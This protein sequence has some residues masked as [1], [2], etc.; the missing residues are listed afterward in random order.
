MTKPSILLWGLGMLLTSIPGLFPENLRMAALLCMA[1]GALFYAMA[2]YKIGASSAGSALVL[3]AASNLAFWLAYGLWHLR[4]NTAGP[5]PKMGVES[6]A[7][8]VS[9]WFTILLLFSLYEGA[10]FLW[11]TIA[12][13]ER[14]VALVG[15]V[16]LVIQTATSTR[17]AY[18]LLQGV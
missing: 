13:R 6:F 18:S 17:L 16:A 4:M 8:V 14:S 3:V 1:L 7:G 15:I 11:G 9:G 5:S 2:A 10:V 12:N